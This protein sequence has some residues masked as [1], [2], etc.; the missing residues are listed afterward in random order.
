MSGNDMHRGFRKWV[1]GAFGLV[2]IIA[3]L[4]FEQAIGAFLTK[5]GWDQ[6][7]ITGWQMITNLGLGDLVAFAFFALGGA[8]LA[9][10]TEFWFRDR[11]EAKDRLERVALSC[12]AKFRFSEDTTGDLSLALDEQSENVAYFAWYLN[13]G[14]S[15]HTTAVM[16]FVEF[17]KEIPAPEVF[18]NAEAGDGE[19]RQ[20]A[21]TDRFTFVELKGWPKGEVV[22]QAFGSKA[23]G[24]DRRS[25]LNVWRP[26]GPMGSSD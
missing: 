4:V 22:V 16:V 18:A 6:L 11:R 15:M 2:C 7:F 3:L 13:N 8:T 5:R 1:S 17:K 21:T 14:G 12:T 26:Y 23:L 25:E 24:L 10:W 19:W 20:F 9:L